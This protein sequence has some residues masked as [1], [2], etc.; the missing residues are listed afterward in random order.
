[1]RC[2]ECTNLKQN[3]NSQCTRAGMEGLGEPV[4]WNE[5]AVAINRYTAFL[6][7]G[8]KSSLKLTVVTIAQL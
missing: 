8:T 6:G 3:V 7:G 2:P 4:G 5:E 1:M